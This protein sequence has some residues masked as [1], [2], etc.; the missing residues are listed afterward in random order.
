MELVLVL[1]VVGCSSKG[2]PSTT[3]VVDTSGGGPAQPAGGADPTSA[4]ENGLQDLVCDRI[5]PESLLPSINCTPKSVGAD[6]D[7]CSGANLACGPVTGCVLE[8]NAAIEGNVIVTYSGPVAGY[9]PPATLLPAMG[10]YMNGKGTGWFGR[11]DGTTTTGSCAFPPQRNIMVAALSTRQFGDADWCGACA[12]V[13]GSSGRRVRIQIV[14]QCAGCEDD[15]LDLGAGDDSPYEMLETTESHPVC[16][17][18]GG[19]PIRW[20]VVPCETVGGIVVRYM[21]GFNHWTPSV[22]ILNHRLPIAK[23]EDQIGGVWQEI[24][25]QADNAYH[26]RSG[27]ENPGGSIIIRITAVDGS[28]IQGAFP[29]FAE[30]QDHEADAQF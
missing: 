22:R 13:V 30:N 18:Y 24:P 27:D 11:N 19:Q 4:V 8:R 10:T 16:Q 20:R 25:R 9:A 15:S 17:P 14:D 6:Y 3:P 21:A 12:E 2:G 29:A 23:L 26:L 7:A 1:A 5:V 28:T